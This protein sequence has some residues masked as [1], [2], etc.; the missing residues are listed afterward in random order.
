MPP[1]SRVSETSIRVNSLGN[2]LGEMSGNGAPPP[3]QCLL[4][5]KTASEAEA[6]MHALTHAISSAASGVA[7]AAHRPEER[8]G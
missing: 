2:E 8:R 1:P 4:R 7:A 5:V 3:F 6:L